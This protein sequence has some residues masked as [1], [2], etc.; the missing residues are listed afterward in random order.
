M[1][2]IACQERTHYTTFAACLK[3]LLVEQVAMLREVEQLDG[4]MDKMNQIIADPF[5]KLSSSEEILSF[6]KVRENSHPIGAR[7]QLFLHQSTF[8]SFCEGFQGGFQ[9]RQPSLFSEKQHQLTLVFPSLRKPP[10]F[11]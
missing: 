2:E 4:V 5:N 11:W 9:L 1:Q 8:F 7:H 10:S 6:V 3:P